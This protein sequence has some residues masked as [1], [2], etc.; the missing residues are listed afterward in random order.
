MTDRAKN[1]FNSP[2]LKNQRSVRQS[3]QFNTLIFNSSFAGQYLFIKI[4]Q[5]NEI[6]PLPAY[7]AK[8]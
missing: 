5:I 1:R 4:K 6:H 8:L 2:S 3:V 7:F